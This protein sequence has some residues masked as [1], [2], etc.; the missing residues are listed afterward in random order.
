MSRGGVEGRLGGLPTPL[1]VYVCSALLL[2]LA[3]RKWQ[4]G[5]LVCLYHTV[6][7]LPLMRMH[8]VIFSPS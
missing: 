6:Q 8:A 5:F 7:N 4:L 2:L 3:L 1:L